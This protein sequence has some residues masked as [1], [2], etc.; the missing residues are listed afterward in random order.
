MEGQVVDKLIISR[1]WQWLLGFFG[2][3][4]VR[5]HPRHENNV[6]DYLNEGKVKLLIQKDQ[7]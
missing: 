1:H 2:C 4:T 3:K 7:I 6:Q 5:G